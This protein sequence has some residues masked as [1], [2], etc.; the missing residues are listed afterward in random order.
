MFKKIAGIFTAAVVLAAGG[1]IPSGAVA[2]S[3]TP[4]LSTA[5][6]SC[7]DLG[8]GAFEFKVEPG[9]F[10]GVFHFPNGVDSVTLEETSQGHFNWTSTLG[11][12]AVIA[13]GGPNANVFA[14]APESKGDTDLYTPVNPSNGK[15]YG[16]SHISFCYDVELQVTK[17]AS[18]SLT[19]T[20]DWDLEK[21]SE[22]STLPL[23]LNAT[24][25]MGYSVTV[26]ATSTDS[27]WAA[28]GTISIFNPA[29]VT[30]TIT[31]VTDE[32]EGDLDATV[33]CGVAMPFD[34]SSGGTLICSY[35]ASLP[36]ATTRMNTATAAATG[37][38][39]GGFGTTSVSFASATVNQVDE[40]IDLT[41][42]MAGSLGQVSATS[43]FPVTIE[44]SALI[45]PYT[46]CGEHLVT[47]TAS[48]VTNDTETTGED[49]AT[50][51]AVI[52]CPV[53]Q[54]CSLSQ[55]YWFSKPGVVWGRNV[56]IGAFSYNRTDGLAIWNSPNKGGIKDAKKAFLQVATI[57]LSSSTISA[58]ANVWPNYWTAYNYLA[59][60]PL[61]LSPSYLPTGTPQSQAAAQA[62]GEIGNWIAE[63]HCE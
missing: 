43:T 29:P 52:E 20:W 18:T 57:Q 2:A 3:V 59:G 21:I 5:N 40:V 16:T 23:A 15:N 26:S 44:Y 45:G 53:T 4:T 31:G 38:V 41:D 46:V 7:A 39:L 63:N 22:T 1:W 34:L 32:L 50:T 55:G 49:T 30:S 33:N 10:T 19:R 9:P 14:Y 11:V 8:Y 12:D 61:K 6:P 25:T 51:T 54:G 13:K 35:L 48:F 58:G 17:T 62:A 27:D 37:T 60:L 42:S 36:D 47:N 28:S 24:G 56:L